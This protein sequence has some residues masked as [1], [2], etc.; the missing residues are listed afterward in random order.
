MTNSEQDYMEE[1]YSS[2]T[3]SEVVKTSSTI[4]QGTN[5]KSSYERLTE[6]KNVNSS[7]TR[8]SVGRRSERFSK[9]YKTSDYSSEEGENEVSSTRSITDNERNRILED[10]KKAAD[11]ST[12]I[13][14]LGLYR[15]AKHYWEEYPKTDWT[16]SPFSK[17]RVEIAPGVVAMP[18]MSRRH[19]S[20]YSKYT[21]TDSSNTSGQSNF[22][23]TRRLLETNT[24]HSVV[25][26]AFLRVLISI[27][28]I[29][30]FFWRPFSY[31]YGF[32]HSVCITVARGIYMGTS[33]IMLLDTWLLKSNRNYGKTA[34][35]T[36]LCVVP[37]FLIGGL[38]LYF[39]LVKGIPF[40]PSCHP[41]CGKIVVNHLTSMTND[42]H[43]L[44]K[45]T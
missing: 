14:A 16:Y 5:G 9:I 45:A 34:A 35:L 43:S 28:S 19:I 3:Y 7:N 13:T 31:F 42:I 44:F 6:E 17:D 11:N 25:K 1:R 20:S 32:L 2:E 8:P 41:N 23:R 4:A 18:N 29:V 10:A 26:K 33:A 39:C 27:L 40:A 24:S 15:K 37:F 22:L 38:Q 12:G 30:H 21:N 36:A